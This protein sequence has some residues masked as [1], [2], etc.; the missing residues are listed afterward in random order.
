M[1]KISF[2][3]IV[4]ALLFLSA[5]N[6][7]A[8]TIHVPADQPTIQVSINDANSNLEISSKNNSLLSQGNVTWQVIGTGITECKS[9]NFAIDATIGQP[10]VNSI[11]S[12][13]NDVHNGF[14]AYIYSCCNKPG[15]ANDNGLINIHDITFLINY[16]YKDGPHPPCFS[17]A[18]ARGDG[19]INISDITYLI[20]YLYK[21][22]PIPQ[23]PQLK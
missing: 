14:W 20:N 11:Q 10:V 21:G 4:L 16:L 22:G 1:G 2:I 17:K 19:P 9:A 18:D 12:S 13:T 23:C 8:A 15:D 3:W 6:A 5:S 7:F